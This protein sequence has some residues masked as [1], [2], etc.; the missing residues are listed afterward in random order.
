MSKIILINIKGS[1]IG[2]GHSN[3]MKN[4]KKGLKNVGLSVIHR[5]YFDNTSPNRHKY[6]VKFFDKYINNKYDQII[7][8]LSSKSIF[9]RFKKIKIM[10]NLKLESYNGKVIIIDSEGIEKINLKNYDYR[11]I[12]YYLGRNINSSLT[13]FNYII[14][15][16][17]LF[18][19]KNI[20]S[21]KK[22][23]LISF[24]ATE[25]KLVIL[26]SNFIEFYNRSLNNINFRFVIGKYCSQE[27]KNKIINKLKKYSNV[28]TYSNISDNYFNY[29]WCNQVITSDGTSKYECI[30]SEKKALIFSS[31]LSN[32]NLSIKFNNLNIFTV[33]YFEETFEN[34]I[35][36]VNKFIN[37]N[38]L[39]PSKKL[40]TYKKKMSTFQKKYSE[41]FK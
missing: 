7:L 39:K 1:F 38:K 32:E 15:D 28:K 31:S 10:L 5:E 14:S 18:N 20:V 2:L 41:L 17:R 19:L 11:V 12:P 29:K 9:R 21:N 30:A 16:H 40:I 33:V 36:K 25:T 37:L 24:G 35:L 3:R 13:G 23:I 26:M 4:L 6:L 22:K 34:K 8:D 27:F